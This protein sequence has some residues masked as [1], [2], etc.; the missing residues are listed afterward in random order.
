MAFQSMVGQDQFRQ[1]SWFHAWNHVRQ[2]PYV[3]L[4]RA[5]WWEWS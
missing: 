1:S 4:I 5:L 2:W 3:V